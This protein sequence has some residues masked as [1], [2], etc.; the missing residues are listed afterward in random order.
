LLGL[1][2]RLTKN[3]DPICTREKAK[4]KEVGRYAHFMFKDIK[5]TS[6]EYLSNVLLIGNILSF[7]HCLPPLF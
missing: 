6:I 7:S 5:Y 2:E 1:I 3:A 4:K